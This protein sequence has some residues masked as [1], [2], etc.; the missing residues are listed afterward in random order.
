MARRLW[1]LLAALT[2]GCVSDRNDLRE[3]LQAE[4]ALDI[5]TAETPLPIVARMQQGGAAAVVNRPPAAPTGFNSAERFRVTVRA[6]VNGIPIFDDDVVNAIRLDLMKLQKS[7]LREPALSDER[8]KLFNEALNKLIDEQVV[9]QDAHDKLKK[10]NPRALE[11]LKE[12]Y[13][14]E[15]DKKIRNILEQ[16]KMTEEQLNAQLKQQN[17]TMETWHAKEERQFIAQ[18]YMRS[19]VM[20]GIQSLITNTAVYEYYTQHQS[21]FVQEDKVKWQDIFIAGPPK[22][23]NPRQVAEELMA[24]WR[25]GEDFNRLLA[26]DDGD[27]STRKG[28]GV[29]QLRRDIRPVEVADQLFTLKEGDIG[30]PVEMATGV[31]IFRVVKRDYAGQIPFNDEVQKTI[32][33]KLQNELGRREEKR[34]MQ[35]LR[36]RV[37]V[38]IFQ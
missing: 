17:M 13:Q 20:G 22:N 15:F 32:R 31:H 3:K 19:R 29:G 8:A 5:L 16:T 26:F 35:E 2:A 6:L 21:E 37:I 24:R 7:G 33:R 34:I 1:F 23:G 10:N 9:Y 38:E 14:R 27:A 11:K 12:F 36:A 4:A 18:E 28:E 25:S 30:Q